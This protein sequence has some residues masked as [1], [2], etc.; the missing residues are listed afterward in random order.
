M[1][2]YLFLLVL[3]TSM[4]AYTIVQLGRVRDVTH[5]IILVDNSV[6]DLHK[7]LTDDLLSETR[8]EKKYVIM[9]DAALLEGF[10]AARRDFERDLE[11]TVSLADVQD[12]REVLA[13][14]AAHHRRYQA[15]F[16]EEV[17]AL[18]SGRPYNISSYRESKENETAAL[19]EE[20]QK[21]RSLVQRNV[22]YKI[23]RLNEAGASASDVAMTVTAVSLVV[24][25]VIALLITRSI[26]VP[27]TRIRK[28]TAEIGSGVYETDLTLASPPEI[29]AL[30]Q[31]VNYMSAKLKEVDRLKADFYALMSHELRTPLTSIREGT[32]LLREG[33]AGEVADRQ[34]RILTII[35]EESDRLIGLVSSLLDLSKLEAGMLSYHFTAGNVAALVSRA[36]GEVVPLAEAKKIRIDRD[37]PDLPAITMDPERILQVLR[38]LVGNA[39]KFTPAG[40]SVRIA[41]KKNGDGI[42]VSVADTGPGIPKEQQEAIFDKFRQ[43]TVDRSRA[44]PG[45]GLGLAIVKLIVQDHG[46]RVWV[47]SEQGRGCTFFFALPA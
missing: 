28:R 23:R 46:G 40:G 17:T 27:L 10:H 12:L 18:R 13:R 19:F 38:N 9:R 1:M 43:A 11:Q 35:A 30:A 20:L 15:L 34:K 33:T 6:L 24:G 29:G 31:S 7:S 16:A 5:S 36:V 37:I 32:N 3:A 39:L 22:I 41:A 4:S 8:Y 2:G 44:V 45:S 47:E 25:I 42:T 14:L 26:T 21:L